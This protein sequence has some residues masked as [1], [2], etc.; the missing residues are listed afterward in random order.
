MV[1]IDDPVAMSNNGVLACGRLAGL[2]HAES[3]PVEV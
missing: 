3:R 1:S 2:E